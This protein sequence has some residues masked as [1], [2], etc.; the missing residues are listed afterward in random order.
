MAPDFRAWHSKTYGKARTAVF[1]DVEDC[2]IPNGSNAV[3]V[4][5]SI[6]SALK[7]IEYCGPASIY[8]YGNPEQIVAGLDTAATV[9][10]HL[11]AGEFPKA[12]FLIS[13][14]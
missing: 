13:S 10:S 3:E 14:M 5:Q 11:A 1:W 12:L 4:S 2:Q 8:A 7:K 9:V 6:R